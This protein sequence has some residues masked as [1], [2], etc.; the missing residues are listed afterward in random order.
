MLR[1]GAFGDI[2]T[3]PEE[4]Q[5]TEITFR[6]ASPVEKAKRQIEEGTVGMAIDKILTV[7][8]IK[9][10]VMNRINWDEYGKF[11]AESNDFPSSLL[12]DDAAVAEIA[13]AQAQAAEEEKA[14]EGAERMAGAAKNMG[15]APDQLVEG[16][17]Q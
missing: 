5:G 3:I 11:I 6:F 17:M 2:N 9:P 16:L 14:M 15:G 12:L 4:L 1:R 7:G 13:A 8:Q 10:E